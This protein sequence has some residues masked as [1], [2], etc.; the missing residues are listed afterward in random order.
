[1]ILILLL[2]G[3][4]ILILLMIAIIPSGPIDHEYPEITFEAFQKFYNINP[5]RWEPRDDYVCCVTKINYDMI[6]KSEKFQF[7]YLDYQ[8]YK[9]WLKNKQE[10]DKKLKHAQSTAKMIAAVKQDIEKLEKISD[11]EINK[12]KSIIEILCEVK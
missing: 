3:L 8:R 6:W 4:P 1:M 10:Y 9:K 7:N 12:A 5:E 11:A 2:I